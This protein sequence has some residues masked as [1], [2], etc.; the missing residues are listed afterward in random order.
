ML[1]A[2]RWTRYGHDRVYVTHSDG[3]KVGFLDL[4][5]GKATIDRPEWTEAFHA[6]VGPYLSSS[7]QDGLDVV[8]A[9][10]E[11][12]AE[13]VVQAD[14]QAD[15]QAE[16]DLSTNTPG[17]GARHEAN[18]QL[19]QMRERSRF[20]SLLARTFDVHTDERA[21]RK[22]AEGE[23]HVGARLER[24]GEHGWRVLHSV[25]VGQ[26]GSDIDHV[27]IGP[28]GVFTV[29]TKNHP[30]KSIW[31]APNQIRVN[32]QPVPYLRNSR[33]EAKRA[34]D[35]LSARVGW[36][37]RARAVLVLLTG[38]LAPQIT[39]K[40]GGPEDVWIL[41]RWDVPKRFTKSAAIL[42]PR[43]VEEA[44]AAARRPETWTAAH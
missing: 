12:E 33:F 41:H 38:G 2:R 14:A 39:I 16:T 40:S 20:R 36:P 34:S 30:G 1:N 44:Y 3:T 8:Q 13:A 9:E 35:L 17:Q 37:V 25:P 27:L 15:A 21:W 7:M 28:G 10:A 4:T 42:T 29:N 24:L 11:A 18:E 19:A 6:V 43:E 22:G 31:V 26:R 23:E 32:G 5:T